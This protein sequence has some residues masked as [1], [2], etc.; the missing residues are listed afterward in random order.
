MNTSRTK[1]DK[2]DYDLIQKMID[3]DLEIKITTEEQLEEFIV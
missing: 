2:I 1:T 3:P